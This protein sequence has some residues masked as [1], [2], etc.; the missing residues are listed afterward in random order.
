MKEG[1]FTLLLKAEKVGGLTQLTQL[2][3]Q[4]DPERQD[5]LPGGIAIG[6]KPSEKN[7]KNEEKPRDDNLNGAGPCG[8][9]LVPVVLRNQ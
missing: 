1:F 6:V 3:R 4:R 2:L 5:S 7:E 9:H 8:F